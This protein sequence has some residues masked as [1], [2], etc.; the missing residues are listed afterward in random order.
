MKMSN[1]LAE[2]VIGIPMV[3]GALLLADSKTNQY[4]PRRDDQSHGFEKVSVLRRMNKLGMKADLF[5]HII[6]EQGN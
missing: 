3:S 5:A 2:K 4:R 1:R 6:R